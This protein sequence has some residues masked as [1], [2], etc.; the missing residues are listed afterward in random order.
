M[1]SSYEDILKKKAKDWGCP[2]M[3][4]RAKKDIPRI[5]FSSPF[6]NYMTYGGIPR[7]RVTIFYGD[8]GG[9]KSSTSID[10][11]KNAIQIFQEEHESEIVRMREAIAAGK[12][13]IEAGE[14]QSQLPV[15]K[16]PVE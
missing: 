10:I 1:A 3:M 12:K 15:F 11:C 4:S 14:D 13:E 8:P 7:N 2:D 6:P 5:P 9:G 16:G